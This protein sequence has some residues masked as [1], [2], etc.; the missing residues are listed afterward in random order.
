MDTFSQGR[1]SEIMTRIKGR[2]TVPER[3]LRSLLHALGYRFRLRRK[4]LPG[5]PDITLP[6]FRAVIFVHG[7]FWHG[8]RNCKRAARPTTN[9]AFWRTKLDKNILRDRRTRRVL[10]EL[11]WKVKIVWQCEL[12]DMTKLKRGVERFLNIECRRANDQQSIDR[13]S[14]IREISVSRSRPKPGSNE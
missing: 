12:R 7:C 5:K 1:R 11:G 3:T 13:S 9:V 6:R 14:R 10:K 2:D 8:H 4:D